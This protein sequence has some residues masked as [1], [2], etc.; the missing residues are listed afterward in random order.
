MGRA[1]F[2]FGLAQRRQH[3]SRIAL[4]GRAAGRG[5]GGRSDGRSSGGKFFGRDNCA[6]LGGGP[7]QVMRQRFG[8]ADMARQVA[9]ARGLACL[10]LQAGQ[11]TFDFANDV[12]QPRQV[13]FGGA[14]AQFRLMAALVQPAN[15][16]GFFQDGAARQRLLRDQQADLALAHERCRTGA[17]RRIGKENLNVTLAHIAAI[18]AIDAAGLALDAT[19]HFDGV[20]IG[21]G[22]ADRAV[23]IVNEQ[24]H[25]RDIARRTPG[26]AGKD[27]IVHLRTAHGRGAR[28]AHHPA[29]GVE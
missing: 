28:L 26:A 15:T 24:R 10:A 13:G 21:I 18:D 2:G 5:F 4:G 14:Q 1:A 8:L 19:R 12:F 29:H 23:A 25:F 22:A 6:G 16:G 11:L 27:H 17:G 3:G 20:E 7:A 9:I